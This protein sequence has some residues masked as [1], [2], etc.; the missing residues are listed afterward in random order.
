MLHSPESINAPARRETPGMTGPPHQE[1]R[2]GQDVP[3]R[4]HRP[5]LGVVLVATATLFFAAMDTMTKYLAMH[6]NVPL[7]MAVRYMVHCLL[8]LSVLAPS[9]GWQL[10]R[11]RRPGLVFVRSLSLVAV[12]LFFGLALQRMPVAES[13]AIVFL[14]PILVVLIAG[15]FLRE[16]I[17]VIGWMAAGFGFLGVVLIVRPGAGLN[18]V[19]LVCVLMAIGANVVY[20][21]LSRILAGN[22]RTL[23][24]LFHSAL[25]GALCFGMLLPWSLAGEPPSALHLMLFGAIGL[26][27]GISHFLF[28]LAYRFSSASQLAPMTYLQLVWASFLGWVVF[29]HMPDRL[30]LLGMV[31]VMVSGVMIALK[32]RFAERE[33]AAHLLDRPRSVAS[34]ATRG[35]PNGGES[36]H[37]AKE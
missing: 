23:T 33:Y 2:E 25:V 21:L 31:I 19:G 35:G 22:E 7:V 15:P 9:Q 24:M 28:T 13:T 12:S 3:A 1:D 20:Q 8:M 14:A 26:A 10:V 4:Q 29:D 18:P 27:G 11:T 34:P 6:Y 5:F 30:G 32:A 36:A 17:G 16:K 37:K